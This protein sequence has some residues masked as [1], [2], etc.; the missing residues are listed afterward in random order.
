M[1]PAAVRGLLADG[2]QLADPAPTRLV[3]ADLDRAV[4]VVAFSELPG[5]LEAV[6]PVERWEVPPVSTEYAASRDAMLARIEQL[7]Q[8]LTRK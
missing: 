8:E 1:A 4:R 3:Q 6:T 7:L 5:D 2:L